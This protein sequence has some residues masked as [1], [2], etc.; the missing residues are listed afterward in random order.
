MAKIHGF[1]ENLE[2]YDYTVKGNI[3]HGD[4]YVEVVLDGTARN[5]GKAH[6]MDVCKQYLEDEI[7]RGAPVF[8]LTIEKNNK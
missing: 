3:P 6:F 1:L 4:E 2:M 5:E 7:T 8:G